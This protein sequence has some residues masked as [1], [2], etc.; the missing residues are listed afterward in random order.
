[1]EILIGITVALLFGIGLYL[2]MRRSLMRLIL[3][4]VLLTHGVNLMLFASGGV[5]DRKA[6]LLSADAIEEIGRHAD[7]LPQALV[8]TAIVISFG[9]LAFTVILVLR[10]TDVLRSDDVDGFRGTEL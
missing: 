9:V 2:I 4:L 7:P 8:L 6:P 10:T 1:V 3:G 5:G